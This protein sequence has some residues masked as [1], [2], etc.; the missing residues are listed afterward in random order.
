VGMFVIRKAT[1]RLPGPLANLRKFGSL[2]IF[3]VRRISELFF[4]Y[5]KQ[6]LPL[7]LPLIT[8]LN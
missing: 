4:R 3:P 5:F 8:Q 2:A 1:S 6:L 7:D